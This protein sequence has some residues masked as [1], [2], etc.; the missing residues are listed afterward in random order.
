MFQ[1]LRNNHINL[2][3]I[4][5]IILIIKE[6]TKT[7]KSLDNLNKLIYRAIKNLEIP[8]SFQIPKQTPEFNQL[9]YLQYHLRTKVRSNLSLFEQLNPILITKT[10]KYNNMAVQV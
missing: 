8:N 6:N 10:C 7:S 4:Q 1:T 9:Y 3:G 5:I 2:I